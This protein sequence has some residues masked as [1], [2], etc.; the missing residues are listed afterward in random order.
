MSTAPTSTYRLQITADFDLDAATDLIGYL[1]DLGVGAL[2]LSPILR[3]V[4]GSNHGYDVVDH[5][6]IDPERGGPDALTRLTDSARSAGLGVIVDV[7]PNHAGVA[8]PP[9]NPAWWDL[10]AHGRESRY[11]HWF[12][13][14]WDRAPILL[15]VLGDDA[16]LDHD[17]QIVASTRTGSGLELHYLDHRFPVASGTGPKPGETAGDVLVR[18]HYRLA[19]YRHAD[20]DQNYRR[21][22]AVTELAGL[23]VE[24][25]D[26]FEATHRVLLDRVEQG[27]ITGLRIDHPDGLVDPEE[28]L[29][30]LREAAPSAWITVEKILE[31]GER[32]PL[33]WPVAGT[34]G[35]DALTEITQVLTDP[36]GSATLST[37]YLE[38]TGDERDFA[39]HVA[40][41]KRGVATT[42]LH[43]EI[44]RLARL[45]P[46]MDGATA[47][48]TELVVAFPVYRSYVP[49]GREYLDEAVALA[50]ARNP[51]VAPAVAALLPRLLDPQDELARRFEQVTG[52]VMAK[53]VED[54]AYYRYTRALWL[55]EVGGDPARIGAD[56]AT[57]HA[58]QRRRQ[59]WNPDGMTTLSTHDTKRS[60]D[61]RARLAVL[62]ELAPRWESD[63]RTL[64]HISPVPD[65]AF[66]LLLWQTFVG[67]GFIDRARMHAYAEKAMREA[68]TGTGWRDP[69]AGFEA[70]VQ[71]AVDAAY[72]DA[73]THAILNRLIEDVTAPGWSNALA[74][75]LIQL[76]M[77]GVPDIYQGTELW[78]DS[79]VDPDNR[80]PVDYEQRRILLAAATGPNP[81]PMDHTGAAKLRV[82]A[83]A[84]HARR[85]RPD[86][87]SR[88]SALTANGPAADHLLAYDRG[89]A[90]TL[91]TRLP[92]GLLDQGGWSDTSLALPPGEY[93]DALTGRRHRGRVLIGD[94]L[95]TYPVALLLRS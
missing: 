58:A 27:G 2:Y 8:D 14:D 54:T 47:A 62:A 78:D 21:F 93:E 79:L 24:A 35:Y 91:A 70:E 71:A 44:R 76:T 28:Y 67:A 75:K 5:R 68:N 45:A 42:I 46:G 92:V 12:D 33:S 66:G 36:D 39:D 40:D 83:R 41:G 56:L 73:E 49:Q 82:V 26:V 32:L 85:D 48:L 81:P 50:V 51:S 6:E 86:L 65:P 10:L 72:D 3:A 25:A 38:I 18:Q 90:I 30:R 16:D 31:P 88:Y 7:V 52:A 13:V 80:R 20:D 60:E 17:L 53:G 95:S 64:H 23:R 43:A 22:F 94:V 55:N 87:F 74:Q 63:A 37:A 29:R 84:L 34:T 11:A 57:F 89:G 4:A 59:G 1:L 15:P 9:Q 77:P 19:G 61:V 69:D